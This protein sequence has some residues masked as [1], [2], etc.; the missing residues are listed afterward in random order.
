MTSA[1]HPN[2]SRDQRRRV[3]ERDHLSKP[4][5]AIPPDSRIETGTRD[6]QLTVWNLLRERKVRVKTGFLYS[7]L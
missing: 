5:S 3:Y 2:A 1:A 4:S 7:A 6:D